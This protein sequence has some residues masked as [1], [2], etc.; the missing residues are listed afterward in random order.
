MRACAWH[1]VKR[2]NYNNHNN[3]NICFPYFYPSLYKDC[4]CLSG[5]GNKCFNCSPSFFTNS[6][7]NRFYNI[8]CNGFYSWNAKTLMV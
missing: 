8:Y 2:R 4:E 3:P 5:H 6:C 1:I 7:Q